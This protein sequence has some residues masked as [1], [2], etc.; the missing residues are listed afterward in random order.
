LEWPVRLAA[1]H[2]FQNAVG[3]LVL[4][5][6]PQKGDLTLQLRNER[7]EELGYVRREIALRD[8]TGPALML[9]DLQL[10]FEITNEEQK[11]ILPAARKQERIVAPYPFDKVRKSLPL[12]CYFEIYN[13]RMRECELTYEII[14][15]KVCAGQAEQGR[16]PKP[17]KNAV[18]ISVTT[19]R[20]VTHETLKELL[21]LDLHRLKKG[22]YCLEVTVANPQD[23][24]VFART[25]R[26]FVLAD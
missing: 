3:K 24:S 10:L 20:T 4:S 17:D 23:R 1:A 19:I 25:D 12:L 21:A 15:S 11:Q 26:H 14:A 9:S 5:A 22:D 6:A 18:A 16:A 7:K 2:A 13:L 8:F